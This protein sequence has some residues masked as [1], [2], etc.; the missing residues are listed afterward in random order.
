M[1]VWYFCSALGVMLA[2]GIAFTF[3]SFQSAHAADNE[4]MTAVWS[5]GVLR[6]AV[7]YHAPHAGAAE[8]SISKG[9][10]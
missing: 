5:H 6:A 10:F 3:D 9:L 8:K 4:P 1:K 7:P 2:I